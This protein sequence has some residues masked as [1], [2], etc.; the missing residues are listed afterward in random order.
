MASGSGG[1]CATGSMER[2]AA[3]ESAAIPA[4]ATSGANLW[5]AASPTPPGAPGGPLFPWSVRCGP[6]HL[7]HKPGP[8]GRLAMAQRTVGRASRAQPRRAR[9]P[10]G[11]RTR[12]GRRGRGHLPRRLTALDPDGRGQEG[13]GRL[14]HVE[15]GRVTRPRRTDDARG[16]LAPVGHASARQPSGHTRGRWRAP[17]R[18]SRPSVLPPA[19]GH[20]R[21]TAVTMESSACAHRCSNRR[22]KPPSAQ[23]GPATREVRRNADG[24][25]SRAR[26]RDSPSTSSTSIC[27]SGAAT[28][29]PTTSAARWPQRWAG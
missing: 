11:R 21:A 3:R 22:S 8:V 18:V 29:S 27:S 2:R 23:E 19:R 7:P 28:G 4:A 6:A 24:P 15:R 25:S 17:R 13:V 16:G 20:G 26:V 1:A 9:C 12:G 5:M 10:A 14:F